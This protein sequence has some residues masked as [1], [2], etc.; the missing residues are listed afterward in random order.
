MASMCCKRHASI[1]SVKVAPDK[2]VQAA[3]LLGVFFFGIEGGA[4]AVQ[5]NLDFFGVMV[6]SFAV[7]L[8]GGVIRDLLIGAS[9]PAAIQNPR[10]AI[11]AFFGGGVTFALSR[12]IMEAPANVLLAFDA[13][14]LSLVAVAGAAKALDYEISP[15]LAVLMGTITGVGGGTIRDIFLAR[16]PAILRVD[17]YAVAALLG[18]AI[19]VLGI[20]RG[21]R[22]TPMMI[23]GGLFCFVLRM[24]AVWQH[25]NLPHANGF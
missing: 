15:M 19:M 24:V 20:G 6:L 25:W 18:A 13:A 5:A 22:R 16:I 11:A 2:L 14:G 8:G 3:D 23:A 1:F 4:A 9:P 17:V 12:I 21:F 7:A 10:Y